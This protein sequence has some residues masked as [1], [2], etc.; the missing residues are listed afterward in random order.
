MNNVLTARCVMCSLKCRSDTEVLK[1]GCGTVH[2]HLVVLTLPQHFAGS[3]EHHSQS[4]CR[5][6][7][8]AKYEY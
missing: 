3:T 5:Q 4:C 8:E 7:G 1:V 2:V 6:N